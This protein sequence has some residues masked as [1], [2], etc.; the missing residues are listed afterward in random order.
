MNIVKK[1]KPK[2]SYDQSAKVELNLTKKI[3]KEK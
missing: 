2:N 3:K 1:L